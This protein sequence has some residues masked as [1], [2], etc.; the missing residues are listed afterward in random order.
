MP[1]T[2]QVQYYG[3]LNKV[4]K[5]E[6]IRAVKN[7]YFRKW[8]KENRDRVKKIQNNYWSRKAKEQK[9]KSKL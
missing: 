7:E 1:G 3:L 2:Q 8:R 4:R 6:E 9:Q 5:T